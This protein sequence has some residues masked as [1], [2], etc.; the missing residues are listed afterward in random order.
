MHGIYSGKHIARSM[1][2]EANR[3]NMKKAVC[4]NY[5]VKSLLLNIR[6]LSDTLA[7]EIQLQICYPKE[8]RLVQYRQTP[9]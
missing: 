3:Q 5:I 2:E 4:E 8:R 6:D 1:E 9:P 7:M